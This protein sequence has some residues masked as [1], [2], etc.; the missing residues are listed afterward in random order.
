M[1]PFG[2]PPSRPPTVLTGPV[3]PS[4]VQFLVVPMLTVPGALPPRGMPVH[5]PAI[6]TPA[7]SLAGPP[8]AESSCSKTN[9][10]IAR[11]PR[12]FTSGQLQ[13]LF[14]P[15]G[16]IVSCRVMN[17]G[18]KR[19]ALGFVQ[20]IDSGAA[21]VSVAQMNGHVVEGK[22]ILVRLADRDK[23][24]GITNPPNERL[25]VANLPAQCTQAELRS[26]L[27]LYGT[28]LKLDMLPLVGTGQ[29]NHRAMVRFASVAEAARAK[30]AL[31]C[32]ALPGTD[33]LLEVKFAEGSRDRQRRLAPKAAGAPTMLC[34]AAEVASS[35]AA[36]HASSSSSSLSVFVGPPTTQ[37]PTAPLMYSPVSHPAPTPISPPRVQLPANLHVTTPQPQPPVWKA[38][39]APKFVASTPPR[40]APP[41]ASK[42][43][44]AHLALNLPV[45]TH[46]PSPLATATTTGVTDRWSPSAGAK[47]PLL[48][49]TFSFL[50]FEP[51][52]SPAGKGQI[53]DSFWDP[54][55]GSRILIS[56]LPGSVTKAHLQAIGAS[57]GM[58]LDVGLRRTTEDVSVA[59]ILFRT[60]EESRAAE[61]RL[62][63]QLLQGR[64]LH[65]CRTAASDVSAFLADAEA[66]E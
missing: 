36:S 2:V 15:F 59:T 63:G 35:S 16:P 26:L 10:Y 4:T 12:T 33:L 13:Q 31:H 62:H 21:E 44:S 27:E 45:T 42:K 1:Q 25:Y 55:A 64:V 20:F 34:P 22:K 8:D 50:D 11:L 46:A 58:V 65:V 7:P 66:P 39:P 40:E 41:P 56:N 23:D 9:V 38:E 53:T 6:P 51:P 30:D 49:T 37:I 19:A 17:N 29:F 47:A 5:F 48:S 32:L 18:N 3:G 28:V 57:F 54:A 24:K 43:N 61:T 52:S 60:A 14:Q